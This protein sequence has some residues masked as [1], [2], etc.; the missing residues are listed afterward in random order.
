[1]KSILPFKLVPQPLSGAAAALPKFKYA[2]E[3]MGTR[4]QLG[5][6]PNFLQ[7]ADWPACPSCKK[8]MTF[9]AQL[10][11]INDEFCIGDCGMIYVFVCLHCL[12]VHSFVQSY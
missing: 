9:Y 5:G 10:D 12:E 6:D 8:H 7:P 2:G 4:H 1:M 3:E 11:S